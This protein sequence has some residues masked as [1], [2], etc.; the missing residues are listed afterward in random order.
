[1][2]PPSALTASAPA[3]A[4]S[5]ADLL[6]EAQRID[7]ELAAALELLDSADPADHQA[8][9]ELVET[10]FLEHQHSHQLVHEKADRYCYVISKQRADAAYLRQE[11]QRLIGLAEARDKTAD[12]IT[13]WMLHGLSALHPGQTRFSLPRHEVTSRANAVVVIDDEDLLPEGCLSTPTPP[14]PKPKPDKPTIKRLIKAGIDVPGAHLEP[15]RS[16]QIK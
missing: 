6:G 2:A 8:A 3:R 10:Y 14:K 12:R 16:W 13:D 5:Y 15:T 7:G 9:S 1:M 11:A 4:D